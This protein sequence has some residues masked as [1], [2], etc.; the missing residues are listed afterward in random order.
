MSNNKTT[1]TKLNIVNEENDKILNYV[2]YCKNNFYNSN[3][4]IV[5]EPCSHIFHDSCINNYISANI[6]KNNSL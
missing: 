1:S 6:V 4:L 3:N 2:C 5:L